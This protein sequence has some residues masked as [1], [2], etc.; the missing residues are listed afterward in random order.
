MRLTPLAVVLLLVGCPARRDDGLRPMPRAPLRDGGAP[1]L[2]DDALVQRL[3]VDRA[4]LR[5][6][7]TYAPMDCVLVHARRDGRWGAWAVD[8]RA[9]T[10]GMAGAT[11]VLRAWAAMGYAPFTEELA[12]VVGLFAAPDATV[13]PR[14]DVVEVDGAP[15][16]AAA[17]S[18]APDGRGGRVLSFSLRG[19]DGALRTASFAISS[20]HAVTAR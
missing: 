15:V 18:A 3:G 11:R 6:V 13:I 14:R 7:V 5:R 10:T 12:R 9:A 20:D 16:W 17:P 2:S 4:T 19:P 8:A 1:D